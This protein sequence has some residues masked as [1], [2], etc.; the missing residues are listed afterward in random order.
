[1]KKIISLF[2]LIFIILLNAQEKKL[3]D[4]QKILSGIIKE[5]HLKPNSDNIFI[6]RFSHFP[7][8]KDILAD[9][10]YFDKKMA[11]GWNEEERNW[12]I[13]NF[14]GFKIFMISEKPIDISY[15]TKQFQKISNERFQN[16]NGLDWNYDPETWAF[17]V[18]EKYRYLKPLHDYNPKTVE[19]F[20]RYFKK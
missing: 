17:F 13:Y 8:E 15:F 2:S 19:S 14:K 12:G 1:M 10:V 4:I 9:L 6:I 18:D 3:N 7:N 5:K 20:K 16:E 11:F